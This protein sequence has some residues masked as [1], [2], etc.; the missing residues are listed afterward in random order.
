MVTDE[1]EWTGIPSTTQLLNGTMLEFLK[2]TNDYYIYPESRAFAVHGT[3]YHD[4]LDS[5][6]LP[7]EVS[8]KRFYDELGS[9][10]NDFYDKHS[11]IL[12]DYK[13]WGSYRVHRF[14]GMAA[15]LT[16]DPTGAVYQRATTTMGHRYA[17][18]HPKMVK[19]WTPNPLLADTEEIELQMNNYRMKLQVAGLKVKQLRVQITVRD[20][21]TSSARSRGILFKM[22]AFPVDIIPD[23]AVMEYFTRKQEALLEALDSGKWTELCSP[24]ENWDGRRCTLKF[25]DVADKCPMGI[26]IAAERTGEQ[27]DAPD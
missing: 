14:L 17:K 3:M 19:I 20:G 4:V 13:T 7:G 8:E 9:G 22:R 25:C 18:G 1:R 27:D 26:Q 10:R 16:E 23:H 12:Y 21:D 6:A 15:E 5:Y 11:K 2:L 24:T